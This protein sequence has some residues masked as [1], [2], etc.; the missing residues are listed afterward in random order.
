MGKLSMPVNTQNDPEV[1]VIAEDIASGLAQ[2]SWLL[3]GRIDYDNI[4][5]II[6][7]FEERALQIP[8]SKVQDIPLIS[9]EIDC[10]KFLRDE[11]GTYKETGVSNS[12]IDLAWNPLKEALVKNPIFTVCEG[13]VSISITKDTPIY[14]ATASTE[15]KNADGDSIA[16]VRANFNNRIIVEIP[17]THVPVKYKRMSESVFPGCDIVESISRKEVLESDY[18]IEYMVYVDSYRKTQV[19]KAPQY[20]ASNANKP[21]YSEKTNTISVEIM[22][23][24]L[25][26]DN[27]IM[28]DEDFVNIS[29]TMSVLCEER[30]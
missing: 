23:V 22:P 8:A 27:E 18:A 16:N 19:G 5:K 21:S 10:N 28:D 9:N 24:L 2:L 26:Y 11:A 17:K 4:A 29:V 20:F 15:R 6:D 13:T 14:G 1:D 7:G 30:I 25:G 12:F 3:E